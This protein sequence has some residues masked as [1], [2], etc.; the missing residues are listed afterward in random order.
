MVYLGYYE[1]WEIKKIRLPTEINIKQIRAG[2]P[3]R[4][5]EG[6]WIPGKQE[7]IVNGLRVLI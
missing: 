3:S 2:I 7:G 5:T 1:K 6:K 4:Q